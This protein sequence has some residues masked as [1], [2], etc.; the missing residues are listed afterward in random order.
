M[1]PSFL[2]QNAVNTMSEAAL[3]DWTKWAKTKLKRRAPTAGD[4]VPLPFVRPLLQRS[5]RHPFIF[6]AEFSRDLNLTAALTRAY[7]ACPD[8]PRP[9]AKEVL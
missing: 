8:I 9:G 2:F 1:Q 6:Q 5:D 4:S 7:A 3:K